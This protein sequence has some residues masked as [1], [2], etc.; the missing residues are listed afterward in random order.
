MNIDQINKVKILL[1]SLI[2]KAIN[3]SVAD[4]VEKCKKKGKNPE[5]PDFI[6][7]L[8]INFIPSL[9][10]ILKGMF[11]KSK[12]SVTG[13]FCH[14]SPKVDI[15]EKKSPEIGDLLLIYIHTDKYGNKKLNSLLL[16]AKV[17][18]EAVSKVPHSDKHQL[19][20]YAEWPKFTYKYGPLKGESRDIQPK[21]LHDG[22]QYLLIDD[23]PTYGLAGHPFTFPMGCAVP[24]KTLCLDNDLATELVDF[25]KFKSGRAFEEN[26]DITNDDWTKLIWELL[27]A[28]KSKASKRKNAG[29]K[30]F[31]RQ[32]AKEWD[33]YCTFKTDRNSVL[34]DLHDDLK[35][36]NNR[37]NINI[38]SN[39]FKDEEPSTSIILIESTEVNKG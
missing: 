25:L 36:D 8:T 20:L 17:T 14:Q 35:G 21:T 9:Y 26:P 10:D 33:G 16:Q 18:R 27:K 24:N 12:F 28:S 11:A 34:N 15:G 22:A 31:P 37:E 29:L 4:I 2:H 19:K 38:D 13:I 5:E 3:N 30:S 32:N 39:L 1:K 23:D 6:A 7:S